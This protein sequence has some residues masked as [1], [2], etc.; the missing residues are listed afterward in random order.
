MCRG[1]GRL[2]FGVDVS[3]LAMLSPRV[4]EIGR[5]LTCSCVTA[6]VPNGVHLPSG[7]RGEM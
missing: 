3:V 2:F 4:S 7:K 1:F 5:R 6:L